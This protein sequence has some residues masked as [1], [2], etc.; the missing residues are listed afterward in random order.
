GTKDE[1]LSILA[2]ELL[3]TVAAKVKATPE[4][5][6]TFKGQ[7]LVGLRYIP[8]FPF[9]Y[10]EFA[11][12]KGRLAGTPVFDE[13]RYWRIVSA[14]FV[15]TDSG[16]GLVH[17][18]PAFGEVDFDVLRSETRR[19]KDGEGP[20]LICA[21]GPD[22]KFTA[23]APTYEGRWVKDV[24]KDI[25]RE[26]KHRGLLFH[27]EQYLH[28]YPFCWRSDK[29][30]L[31]QYPRKSWFIRTSQFVDRLVA[32]NRTINWYPEHIK[33]GRFGNFLA[34]N[35]D[36]ALSRE[37]YWGTPLPI[38]VCEQ[39]GRM[40][41]IGSY[42]ELLAKPGV[43]GLDVWET[44]KKSAKQEGRTLNE[45]LK[46][47]K[48]YIDAVSY[49]SPFAAGS[50]MRRVPEVIDCW[51]DSGAM[52][53]AQWGYPHEKGSKELFE[54]NF[55]A[56]FI[57]EA[58]DQTRG[59]FYSQHA[60]STL[61][62]DKPDFRN[63]IVLGLML[64]EDG[65]KMSKSKRNYRE[66]NEI[67]VKYG[68]D[69]LRWYLFANQTP[70]TAIRYSEQAIKDSM[71]EF[72]LRLTNV[73]SF[74]DVYGKIDG[75]DPLAEID[76][77]TIQS[78]RGQLTPSVLQSAKSYVPIAGRRDLERWILGE[79]NDMIR[80][81]TE[82][83]DAYDHYAA[84]S[85]ITAFVDSLSNWYVRRS[86]DRF[87]SSAKD[88]DPETIRS[89]N[90]AYWTL[91]ECLLTLSKTIAPFVPFL[92]ERMWARL[93]NG[94]AACVES[95][96]LCEYP[97]A[98]LS[99]VD[100]VLSETI[101]LQREIVSLGRNARMNAKLKVRQPLRQIE[102]S[103]SDPRI[104]Q[105]FSGVETGAVVPDRVKEIQE[106]LNVKHVRILTD[107][108]EI[109]RYVSYTILPNLKK[110]GREL[111][112]RLP[113]LQKTLAAADGAQLLA[114]MKANEKI[115]LKID[116]GAVLELLPEDIQIRLAAKEGWAAADGPNCVVVLST[117]LSPELIAEGYAREI[118]RTI[119]NRRKEIG[120]DYTDRIDVGIVTASQ[121]IVAAVDQFRASIQR[122][123][124]AEALRLTSAGSDNVV[125]RAAA[126][127]AVS[128][129]VVASETVVSETVAIKI[130]SESLELDVRIV[131]SRR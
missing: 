129:G 23:E 111:G 56:D 65:Q 4:I 57:S 91:F 1:R 41:A 66:P 99:T 108:S 78:D 126:A 59:W 74:Y 35:V 21:V 24:D 46:I 30:P 60:I 130:D 64:G 17:Q 73:L 83:M 90:E 37:R 101:A 43:A 68:A 119:Q 110:L 45:D 131:G 39:S 50:R 75:F 22:G 58:L 82:K 87:W 11:Q 5:L 9:Y 63:C 98:D 104:G 47:H 103:S 31:I 18:A 54:K 12:A 14:D 67:F 89:K 84:C 86:R 106:E 28:D 127:E 32:L 116:D 94:N 93:T 44:A 62:F 16:T 40:E 81:V 49:D 8:P 77:Q 120:C 80:F 88:T 118:I 112:K 42:D 25:A 96:H 61:V 124:L 15:T 26:L 3:E 114:E 51:Y 117:E 115:V 92:A 105:L 36:W 69:A 34:T 102:I 113:A 122:E 100:P 76:V 10:D 109:A 70:W 72:L 29:D 79:L 13:Y 19:F 33:E 107:P 71:P 2:K 128:P 85:R 27:Q 7:H 123:T 125:S 121:H 55:P 6:E 97:E 52:P 95:V 53:F 20:E 38:W 48:P